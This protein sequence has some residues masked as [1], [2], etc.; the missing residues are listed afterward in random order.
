[1]E[2]SSSFLRPRYDRAVRVGVRRNRRDGG[3]RIPGLPW[4]N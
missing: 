1:M 2:L 3:H 4:I